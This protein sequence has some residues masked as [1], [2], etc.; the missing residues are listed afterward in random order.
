MVQCPH[1][2]AHKP[3][4]SERFVCLLSHQ[5]SCQCLPLRHHLVL[6]EVVDGHFQSV[7]RVF[8][9]LL[10]TL[11]FLVRN[12]AWPCSPFPR[13]CFWLSTCRYLKR[14]GSLLIWSSRCAQGCDRARW[15]LLRWDCHIVLRQAS[16]YSLCWFSINHAFS[17]FQKFPLVHSFV[18]VAACTNTPGTRT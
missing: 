2:W 1:P 13:V 4:D 18:F 14:C 17:H 9:P 3:S 7:A 8:Y 5:L 15:L 16:Q 11:R 12:G 6:L 10:R